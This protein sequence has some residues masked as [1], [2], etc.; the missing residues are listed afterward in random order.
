MPAYQNPHLRRELAAH[1]TDLLR[2]LILR[3]HGYEVTTT[4][5]TMSH[6]TPKN[7][8]IMAT[9]RGNYH[10]ESQ[11]E[12]GELVRWLGG[13]EIALAVKVPFEA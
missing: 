2:V 13:S 4:E 1:M 3:G 5:F 10:R 6:A 7:T 11:A 8:L 12:Y 9:R